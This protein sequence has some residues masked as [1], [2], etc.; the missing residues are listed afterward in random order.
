[1]AILLL[2]LGKIY[3]LIMYDVKSLFS[4]EKILQENDLKGI[5]SEQGKN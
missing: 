5:T 4:E 3:K 1:M 2:N